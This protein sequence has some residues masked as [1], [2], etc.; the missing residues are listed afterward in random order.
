VRAAL[1]SLNQEDFTVA[2][3]SFLNQA[4]SPPELLVVERR[5]SPQ[6]RQR[7]TAFRKSKRR[8]G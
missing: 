2:Q 8:L 5:Q 4:N 1:Q 7:K 6:K 3:Y